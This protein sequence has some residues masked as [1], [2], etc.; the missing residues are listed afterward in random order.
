MHDKILNGLNEQQREAVEYLDSPIFLSAG[1]GSGK[2]KV[3]THKIAYLAQVKGINLQRILAI[4]FTKKAAK[5]MSERVERMQARK[6][7]WI[8]TFHAFAIRILREEITAL[9]R[10]FNK[11]F[12][13]Y[14]TD[15]SLKTLKEVLKKRNRNIKDADMVR[16]TISKAKQK[17]RN[18]II[19]YIARLP[20]P[21]SASAVIAEEYQKDLEA[22]NALDFDDIIYMTAELL[23]MRPEILKKWQEKFDYIMVDEFQDT[24]DIQFTL[25]KLL[26]AGRK[27]LF[28][29]GDYFQCVYSWRGSQPA[30]IMGFV[31]E[32]GARAMK[33]EKNY[34]SGRKIID[35]ANSVISKAEDIGEE[36]RLTLYTDKKEE[37]TVEY[38][39]LDDN[40]KE[41]VWIAEKIK[42]LSGSH[43]FSD[44]AI[45]IRMSFLSR[46]LESIFMQYGIPYEIA[47]GHA[48]YE[49]T[50]VRDMLCYL[51]FMANWKDKAAFERTINTPG[52]FIGNKALSLIRDNYKTDWL[53]AL[54]DTNLSPRQRLNANVFAKTITLHSQFIDEKPFTVLMELIED[55]KYLDYLKRTYKEDAEDRIQNVSELSNV[56]K[57][58][59]AEGKTFSEFMEDSLLSSEQDKISSEQSVKILTS[60]A[61][62]GLEWPVVFLPA[63]EEEIFP[64]ARSLNNM[65]ALEE[66]RRLFYVACTRAKEEL[67]LSS[68]ET[69]MRFGNIKGMLKS[70]Y[71]KDIDHHL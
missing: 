39:E 23:S 52:R 26:A 62:K 45:L 3:L 27:G 30:N 59:E 2:T 34:R 60:H 5:E 41:C 61:A 16:Q 22:S 6:P 46:G 50:E 58:V 8:S 70:R 12:I 10:N 66:E 35:I 33:L 49:R 15:D 64:S 1:A 9:G 37:G 40:I 57:N 17:L 13:I 69:R 67:Y 29:V 71:L 47:S 68:V 36:K 55:I 56:L 7:A 28:A 65:S 53:Q 44:I 11:N 63:L 31:R 14:D 4:T 32:F 42:Q 51:R 20:Y 38:R 43:S 24:N 19:E 18:N 21:Q 25:I 54:K 48:F